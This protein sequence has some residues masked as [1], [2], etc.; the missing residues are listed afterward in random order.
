[1]RRIRCLIRFELTI[2]RTTIY[3]FKPL[4]YR[5]SF[6]GGELNPHLQNQSLM[7]RT[8]YTTPKVSPV[9]VEPT[10]FTL[11]DWFYRPVLDHRP[12]SVEKSQGSRTRTYGHLVPNQA[13]YQL[14]YTLK[15]HKTKK[16]PL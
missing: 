8:H 5:H 4:S 13:I 1:M 3:R 11:W 12:S 9:G 6:G 7:C 14:I 15:C 16:P 2:S 10:L